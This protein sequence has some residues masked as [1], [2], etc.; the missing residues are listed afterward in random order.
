MCWGTKHRLPFWELWA[1]LS[2]ITWP[3]VMWHFQKRVLSFFDSRHQSVRASLFHLRFSSSTFMQIVQHE[4]FPYTRKNVSFLTADISTACSVE[5]LLYLF[6]SLSCSVIMCAIY[7]YK[8]MSCLSKWTLFFLTKIFWVRFHLESLMY[9]RKKLVV[10]FM[11]TTCYKF[12]S[13]PI[14][15]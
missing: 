2:K 12:L 5:Q 4:P 9:Y 14:T 7:V 1:K 6:Y 10:V 15:I 13:L 3:L 11:N 8:Y